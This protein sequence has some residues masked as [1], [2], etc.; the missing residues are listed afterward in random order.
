MAKTA[1]AMMALLLTGTLRAA[2]PADDHQPAWLDESQGKKA[3]QWVATEQ[4][5]TLSTLRADPRFAT[6]ERETAA[7]LTDPTR[8]D[9][10]TF[11][12]SD[13]YQ[14]RRDRDTPLGVWRRTPRAAYFAGKPTWETVIDLDA[15]AAAEKKKF[16]FGGASCHKRHCLV[17][18][19]VN[20]K[21]SVE[22]REFDLDTK[23]FIPGGFFIP[24]GKSRTWWYDDDTLL[25]APILGADSVTSSLVPKTL[26][27]WRRG[28]ALAAT[29]PIFSIGD[30]DAA[31]SVSQ[32]HAAGTDKFIAARHIDFEQREY[33]LMAPDGAS[34]PLPLP[35]F[36]QTMGQRAGKLLL[37]PDVDWTP[38]GSAVTFPAGSLVA[39]SLDAL[40]KQ[41]RIGDAE[42]LYR[43]PGDDALRGAFT[44]GDRLFVELLH[45]YF[46]RIVE[47]KP[48][49]AGWTT[50]TLPLPSARYISV[51]GNDQ[52]KLLL[53]EEAPLVPEK[54]VLAD[55]DTGIEQTLYQ[56]AAMFDATG[57][58][59]E[60]FHTASADGT[61]IDYLITHPRG[62]ALDGSHPTLVYG[63]GGYDVPVTPRYEPIFGKLWMERGGVYVHAYLRGGGEQGPP[64][65]RGSMREKHPNAFDD[66]AAV[67]RD[68]ARRGV[69]APSHL[70]IMG[71]SN[72]GLMTA[73]VMERTPQ[74]MNAVV[75]GGPLI[76]ML[77]FDKLPPGGTW[78][79]E[80]GDPAVPG[81]AAFLRTYSPMQNIADA[82]HPYPVPLIITATDDDRVLPG[83]ARRFAWQLAAHGHDR[84][85]FEDK[86]GGHYW[87]LGGG[88]IPG[89]WRLRITARAVEYTYLWQ[90]LGKDKAQ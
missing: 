41:G 60:L 22:A 80:Y 75:V 71:R 26:R 45:D 18:L 21:D 6:F 59:T 3:L 10:P 48:G 51:L 37:R 23:T 55:P 77:N 17:R 76:D 70:G 4:A 5:R 30:H 43:P 44:V 7:I 56:R 88:P 27:L 29:R 68:L 72:G 58:E 81:D 61:P 67:L 8:I 1:L 63:Y 31:L 15:L 49:S 16:I 54:V 90:R 53:Q 9:D 66:M 52:G 34:Q 24:D 11:I 74:L 33:R 20:G 38:P 73:A 57:L 65:H 78:L 13:V 14:Y 87:E 40:M 19:S 69:S 82:S 36:A 32:I 47:L 84:L 64:W 25:I 12:G 2:E 83:H 86:Q 39:I 50:R 42:L 28:T 85:Y 62:M 46:S 89:D 79:A 35:A